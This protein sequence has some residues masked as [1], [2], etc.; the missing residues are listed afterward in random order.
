MVYSR[1]VISI[2]VLHR[3]NEF[4]FPLLDPAHCGTESE[5]KVS[6]ASLFVLFSLFILYPFMQILDLLTK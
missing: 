5:Q 2:F 6:N 1:F 4:Q 3:L